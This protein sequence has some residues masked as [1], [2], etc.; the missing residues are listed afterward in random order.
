[1][2]INGL[3]PQDIYKSYMQ[4]PSR[5]ETEK[6]SAK[7]V[8]TDRVEISAQGAGITG[9]RELVKKSGINSGEG[10]S[11]ERLEELKKQVQSGSY[12]VSSKDIAQS[13]LKGR[14][15]DKKA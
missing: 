11:S 2:K 13:I 4:S 10:A 12:S 14:F 8:K 3:Q 5:T 6:S 7:E 9:A 15:L 1:M